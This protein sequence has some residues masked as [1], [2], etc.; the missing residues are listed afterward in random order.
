MNIDRFCTSLRKIGVEIIQSEAKNFS[1]G[2]SVDADK[3]VERAEE[4]GGAFGLGVNAQTQ[5]IIQGANAARGAR[6]EQVNGFKIKP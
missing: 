6:N 1:M 3:L 5:A 2:D 4:I